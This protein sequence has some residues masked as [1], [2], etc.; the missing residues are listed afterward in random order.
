MN[1]RRSNL[2]PYK[3]NVHVSFTTMLNSEV[4]IVKFENF[5]V[6]PYSILVVKCLFLHGELHF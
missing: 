3:L 1:S 5:E 4:V 2:Q 6:T